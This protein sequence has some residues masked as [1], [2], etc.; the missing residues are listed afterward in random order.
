VPGI[1]DR[2]NDDFNGGLHR[3]DFHGPV[4]FL[5]L[6]LIDV[7]M[8]SGETSSVRLIDGAGRVRSYLV[9]PGFTGDRIQD[10]TSGVRTLD[11]VRLDPQPG[12]ASTATGAEDPGFDRDAAIALEVHLGGS[13]AVDSLRFDPQR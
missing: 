8:G 11:L 6:D 7:D 3:L 4:R 13:G 12:F 1:F 10:G 2:P 9:P 5:A